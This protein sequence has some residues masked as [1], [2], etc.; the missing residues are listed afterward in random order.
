MA[1]E[2]MVLSAHGSLP[3]VL[4]RAGAN[5]R[6]ATEEFFKA[7]LNNEH[8]RRAYA[9]IVKA[10]LVWCDDRGKELQRVTPGDA[11]QYFAQL[12]GSIPTK[13]QALA[14][15]RHYFDVLV[16]RHAVPLNAF[17]SVRGIKHRVV[18]GKTA[19]IETLQAR[20]LF[21][22]IDAG[23]SV[24][25]RDRAVLAVLAYTGARVGAVAKLRLGDL[26]RHG[27]QW[28]LRFSE[29]GGK[30]RDIPVRHDLK[31]CLQ[32]YMTAAAID[33]GV[34]SAPLF[35]AAAG[36]RKELTTDPYAAHSM[37]QM[38]KR[39]LKHAG[40]SAEFS[41]HSFRVAVV[42]DLLK[43]D[44]PLEDVQYLA[45]HADPKT[46][47]IY[48]RRRRSVTRNTVERISNLIPQVEE[49]SLWET[50]RH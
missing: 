36:R 48:D 41:P 35:R 14:A 33:G 40:L 6:F 17:A 24:G 43:Q 38:L 9:R 19:E 29:K 4:E 49:G 26:R 30:Q 25:L 47:L 3:A 12:Q 16:T 18:E 27:E 42:T 7:M 32:E 31:R 20:K 8:T 13:N 22:T 11:G 46:T 21:R 44:V 45:G 2:L 50:A 10:F 1:N 15:L 39:R 23:N 28:S 5:A 34:K 37:R